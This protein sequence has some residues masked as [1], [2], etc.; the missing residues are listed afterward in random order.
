MAGFLLVPKS[1]DIRQGY[2]PWRLLQLR[3]LVHHMLAGL[4]IELHDLHF[5]GHGAL[6]FAGGI[7]MSGTGR[8]FQFDFV[9]HDQSLD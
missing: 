7:E 6:V 4:G 3:F 1:L 2:Q 5:F 9:S 8:R